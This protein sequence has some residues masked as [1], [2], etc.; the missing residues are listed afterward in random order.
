MN[1]NILWTLLLYKLRLKLFT[2]KNSLK[3][4]RQNAVQY[5]HISNCQWCNIEYYSY[6]KL[7]YKCHY[8]NFR[9]SLLYFWKW[10]IR[11]SNNNCKKILIICLMNNFNIK[12]YLLEN[13]VQTIYQN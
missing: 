3:L 13:L 7:F 12:G 5:I 2:K 1:N 11:F 8:C 9:H 10:N 4:I 6:K